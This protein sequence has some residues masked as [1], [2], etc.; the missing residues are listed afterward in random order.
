MVLHMNLTDNL[1]SSFTPL[2][3][4]H[5]RIMHWTSFQNTACV[6][7]WSFSESYYEKRTSAGK[8]LSHKPQN[9]FYLNNNRE[10]GRHDGV[11]AG[12]STFSVQ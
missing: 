2:D 12:I 6:D 3:F 1:L 11:A 10:L 5:S 9:I 4:T 8:E 7:L